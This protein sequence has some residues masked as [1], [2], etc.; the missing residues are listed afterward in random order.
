MAEQRVLVVED[1]PSA[2]DLLVVILED[3]GYKVCAVADGAAALEAAAT[4]K[5]DLALLDGG[6]PASMAERSP[7]ACAK[8]TTSPSSS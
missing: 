7:V 6:L 4:F 8:S 3:D 1:D 2:R 5:P